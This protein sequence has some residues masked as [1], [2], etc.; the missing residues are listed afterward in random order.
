[1]GGYGRAHRLDLAVVFQ[2]LCTKSG[3]CALF[4]GGYRLADVVEETNATGARCIKAHLRRHGAHE[5]RHL[6]G[7]PQDV[8]REGR[9]ERKRAHEL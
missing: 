3:M 9:A 5:E 1:M 2:E 7:M 8:L 6:H 4:L